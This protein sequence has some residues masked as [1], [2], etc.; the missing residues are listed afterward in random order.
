MAV[1]SATS[2]V[3]RL[4]RDGPDAAG[5]AQNEEELDNLLK[6]AEG[7]GSWF[8]E[9]ETEHASRG[10]NTEPLVPEVELRAR[11]EALGSELASIIAKR[12]TSTATTAPPTPTTND[13]A[14]TADTA[15][16]APTDASPDQGAMEEKEEL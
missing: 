6:N 7:T 14:T 4:R 13:S 15:T 8:A 3:H 1:E 16:T 5:R 2:Y 11:A 9:V 10:T 12:I